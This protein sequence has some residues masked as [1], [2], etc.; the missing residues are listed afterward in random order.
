MPLR[1]CL[2]TSYQTGL[3]RLHRIHYDWIQ[4]A[5]PI[6]NR[7][8]RYGVSPRWFGMRPA[9]LAA[10]R[11]QARVDELQRQVACFSLGLPGYARITIVSFARDWKIPLEELQCSPKVRQK[12]QQ[13]RRNQLDFHSRPELSL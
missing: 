12:L 5:R 10:R 11:R 2:K 3:L 1:K 8:Q 7:L 9:T 6:A 4:Y 13:A